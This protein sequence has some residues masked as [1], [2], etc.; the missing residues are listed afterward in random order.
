LT[1]QSGSSRLAA[2]R[3]AP[4]SPGQDERVPRLRFPLRELQLAEYRQAGREIIY[5]PAV[6]P[7]RVM[8]LAA[9]SRLRV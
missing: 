2:R 5:G 1:G 8:S 4:G 9:L 6:M 3:P 7:E